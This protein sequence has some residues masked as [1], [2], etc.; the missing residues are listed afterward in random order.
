VRESAVAL[1]EIAPFC[2]SA[3]TLRE[4]DARTVEERIPESRVFRRAAPR[5]GM[6]LS[7]FLMATAAPAADGTL[8]E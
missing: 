7:A 8:P 6:T 5:A 3:S 4:S 1:R 2:E